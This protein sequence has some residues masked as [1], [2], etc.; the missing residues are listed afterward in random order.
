[1]HNIRLNALLLVAAGI[2][3]STAMAEDQSSFTSLISKGFEV[4]SVVLVPLEAAKRAAE[5]VST[6]TVIVTLQN[7][8]AVAVCY[9]ALANWAYMNKAS[10][11]TP[12][13][14]EVR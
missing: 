1:M 8:N 7:K 3:S 5:N 13:L 12:T 9:L 11:D 10:L 6:D 14:C 4:K 2:M